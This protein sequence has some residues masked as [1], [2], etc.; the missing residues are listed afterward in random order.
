MVKKVLDLTFCFSSSVSSWEKAL[1]ML[2]A[3]PYNLEALISHHAKIDD[4]K[5]VFSDIEAGNAIKALF[6][7]G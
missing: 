2:A 1:A 7:P 3:S 4:W 6:T 5:K